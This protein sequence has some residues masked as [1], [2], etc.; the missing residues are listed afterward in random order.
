MANGS[1]SLFDHFT[2]IADPRI[3]RNRKHKL[4]DIIVLTVCAVISGAETW[5]DI[6]D[7]GRYKEKWLTRFLPLSNGIPS[8]DTIRR[9]FIRLD[10]AQLQR[11]FLSWVEAVRGET[12]GD[13]VAIDG[14]TLRRSAE[15][16]S[17]QSPLHMVSA[18]AAADGLVLGQTPTASHSNEITAIPALLE[19][20]KINGCVVTIDAEGLQ[21]EI[22]EKIVAKKADYVIALKANQP[23]VHEDVKYFF[24]ELDRE[25][26]EEGWVTSHKTVDKGHGRIEVREYYHCDEVAW[27]PQLKRF[28]GARSIGMV[29]ATRETAAGRSTER[30]YYVSSLPMDAERF[31]H[32]VRTHWSVENSLHWTLDMT[33]REDDSRM[34]RG[35]SAEN[36]AMMRRIALSLVKRDTTSKRSLKR[37]RRICGYDNEY[38]ERLLFNSDSVLAPRPPS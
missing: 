33:F 30:R 8:H 24:R 14:K 2:E 17:G 26:L 38:L 4:L 18:W 10:P 9:V 25:D 3:E 28:A 27:L 11:C 15:Q 5:E 32:A 36:F 13:V 20:L 1:S 19:L 31:A 22:T 37:R 6:E 16:A 21:R 29:K 23:T 12:D 7:Y 35:Y 34:R